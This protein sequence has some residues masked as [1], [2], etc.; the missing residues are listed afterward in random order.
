MIDR[1][2]ILFV[3]LL[4]LLLFSSSPCSAT[5]AAA[6]DCWK[7]LSFD[8][9]TVQDP[10]G[11][12][13]SKFFQN[14]IADATYRRQLFDFLIERYRS[15]TVGKSIESILSTA[16]S[17]LNSTYA[18][19]LDTTYGTTCATDAGIQ[20]LLIVANVEELAIA[21]RDDWLVIMRQAM[22]C[23]ENEVWVLNLDC[24]CKE[25]K[26]CDVLTGAQHSSAFKAVA[27]MIG[28][29]GIFVLFGFVALT[30]QQWAVMLGQ[31]R[32]ESSIEFMATREYTSSSSSKTTQLDT[33]QSTSTSSAIRA[34]PPAIVAS[35]STS[36]FISS[37]LGGYAPAPAPRAPRKIVQDDPVPV[38]ATKGF[39]V[40]VASTTTQPTQKSQFET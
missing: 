29:F 1:L 37:S 38:A 21:F 8:L 3:V 36:S 33:R 26:D 35:P 23:S 28:I 20:L 9:C 34:R 2:S 31:K 24:V 32:L 22:H 14:Q 25:D 40:V 27:L 15:L 5:S 39:A 7:A 18:A 10:T 6:T 17:P 30:R 11:I 19:Y 4:L 16:F 12:C 13:S